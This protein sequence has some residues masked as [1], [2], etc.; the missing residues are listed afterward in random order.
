MVAKAVDN[1]WI[2]RGFKLGIGFW[3]AGIVA[4]VLLFF[5]FAAIVGQPTAP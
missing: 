4:I 5:A 2:M 1:D 3:L